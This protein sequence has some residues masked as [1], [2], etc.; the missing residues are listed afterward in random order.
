[1]LLKV[2]HVICVIHVVRNKPLAY[3]P[4]PPGKEQDMERTY[5]TSSGSPQV[6]K[7]SGKTCRHG[8]MSNHSLPELN[9]TKA[10]NHE[11]ERQVERLK[12]PVKRKKVKGEEVKV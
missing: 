4:C 3:N 9:K 7:N 2:L 6:S 1:M 5:S 11:L 12:D 8:Q 10:D